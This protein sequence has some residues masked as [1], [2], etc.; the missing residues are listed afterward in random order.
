MPLIVPSFYIRILVQVPVTELPTWI[1]TKESGK[2]TDDALSTWDP[3]ISEADQDGA[4]IQTPFSTVT[5]TIVP[6]SI[7]AQW[8]LLAFNPGPATAFGIALITSSL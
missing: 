8:M 6:P 4:L 3:V 5:V 7:I 1:P 2:G